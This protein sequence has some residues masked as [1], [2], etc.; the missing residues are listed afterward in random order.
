[1]ASRYAVNKNLKD[2]SRTASAGLSHNR[3]RTVM[4]TGEIALALFLLVGSGLLIRGLSAIHHQNL[5]FRADH[6]L[7]AA[8]TLDSAQYKNPAQQAAFVR[9]A[10]FRLQQISGAEAVAA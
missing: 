7:T 4:V 3:L 10:L 1:M 9:D 8:V 6:L 2:Q 5:G